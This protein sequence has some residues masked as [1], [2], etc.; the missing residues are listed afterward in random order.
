MMSAMQAAMN[1]RNEVRSTQQLIAGAVVPSETVT[2][3]QDIEALKE[4]NSRIKA[5]NIALQ[6]TLG[7]YRNTI[8]VLAV[9]MSRAMTRP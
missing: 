4:E 5:E 6:Q 9:E 7:A 2:S 3:D 1:G 8:S